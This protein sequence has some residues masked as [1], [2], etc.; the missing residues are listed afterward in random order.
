MLRIVNTNLRH[1]I[2]GISIASALKQDM[3]TEK[4]AFK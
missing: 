4:S 1:E 2:I 3:K